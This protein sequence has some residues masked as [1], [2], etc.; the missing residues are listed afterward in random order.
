MAGVAAIFN[1]CHRVCTDIEEIQTSWRSLGV[2][3]HDSPILFAGTQVKVG[4]FRVLVRR[5]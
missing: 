4:V 3:E 2:M 5:S 1:E